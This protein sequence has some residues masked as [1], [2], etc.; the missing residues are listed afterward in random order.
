MSFILATL[1]RLYVNIK[2]FRLKK[3]Q[4]FASDTKVSLL[5]I[6]VGEQTI[7]LLPLLVNWYLKCYSKVPL[8]SQL[9]MLSLMMHDAH[10]SSLKI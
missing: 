5:V 1:E 7:Y 2:L 6:G 9:Q 8:L 4:S 10:G 3:I